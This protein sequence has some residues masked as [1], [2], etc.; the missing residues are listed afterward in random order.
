MAASPSTLA[1]KSPPVRSSE[2]GSQAAA[3]VPEPAAPEISPMAE[4]VAQPANG[5]GL[6]VRAEDVSRREEIA[7]AAYL[8]AEARGFEPGHELDDWLAAERQIGAH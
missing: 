6:P 2:A 1:G 3:E 5:D 7:C 8:M 4:P